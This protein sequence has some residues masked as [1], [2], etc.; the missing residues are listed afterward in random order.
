[1]PMGR[2]VK[3]AFQ[4]KRNVNIRL[5][6]GVGPTSNIF[7]VKNGKLMMNSSLGAQRI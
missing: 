3:S 2:S 1:M 5:G 4:S 6:S 7:S